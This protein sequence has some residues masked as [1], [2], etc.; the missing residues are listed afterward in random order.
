[1]AFGYENTRP[2]PGELDGA[3]SEIKT[4]E[5]PHPGTGGCLGAGP[6][7]AFSGGNPFSSPSAT[8]GGK[9]APCWEGGCVPAAGMWRGGGGIPAGVPPAPARGCWVLLSDSCLRGWSCVSLH[10]LTNNV[11]GLV[12]LK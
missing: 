6:S 3:L 2:P 10:I 11:T 12:A 8:L 1:M 5:P 4:P 9:A 7:H